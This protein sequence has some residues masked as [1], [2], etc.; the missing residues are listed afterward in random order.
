MDPIYPGSG[1]CSASAVD[2]DVVPGETD[3][4][5]VLAPGGL[6][7]QGAT[8][9]YGTVRAVDRVSLDVRPDEL[10]VVTGS[11][12]SGKSSLIRAV[13]GLVPLQEGTIAVDGRMARTRADWRRRRSEVVYVPQRTAPG[14]FPLVVRELVDSGGGGPEGLAAA[15][16][17][18]IGALLDRPVTTLSGGQL[19]RAY[20]ARAIGGLANTGRALLADEPT[21]A[22]DFAGQADV[23][24]LLAELH[25]PRLVVSHDAAVVARADRVLEMAGGQIRPDGR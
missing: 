12:G 14:S 17:L 2:C 8:I 11:N 25:G 22:L 19:Q 13:L 21:S 18:G 5:V 3:P 23:A 15:E 9:C 6:S 1:N 7:I 10:V 24:E 4:S 20:L 16:R